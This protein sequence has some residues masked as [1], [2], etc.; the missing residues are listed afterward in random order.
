MAVDPYE[1]IRIY[2]TND[3]SKF[4]FVK[5][6]RPV[7]VE[8]VENIK[9]KIKDNGFSK[10]YPIRVVENADGKLAIIS[11]QHR[12]TASEALKTHF[13]Y[14][15]LK[16]EEA[17]ENI[18]SE[19]NGGYREWSNTERL[20]RFI[21]LGNKNYKMFGDLMRSYKFLSVNSTLTLIY[22][23]DADSGRSL[24]KDLQ[25]R[26]KEGTLEINK[27]QLQAAFTLAEKISQVVE[28]RKEHRAIAKRPSFIRCL[29]LM[30]QHPNF[31]MV[32]FRDVIDNS[33]SGLRLGTKWQ[34]TL[35]G[36]VLLYNDG[37]KKNRLDFPVIF[38][39]LAK[40]RQRLH[41]GLQ[42]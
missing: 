11:G 14:T 33:K 9:T 37:I 27:K 13:Y 31:D 40:A 32:R 41:H 16:P 6:N 17:G 20:H 22:G 30:L 1:E 2:K 10:H 8:H 15:L 36:L 25:K 42:P 26:F 39:P 34:E 12:F 23:L 28:R 5:E 29:Y 4:S 7:N 21:T 38:K 19:H 24:V 18:L 3:F 35:E